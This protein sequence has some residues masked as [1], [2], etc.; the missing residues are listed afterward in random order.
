MAMEQEP[1]EIE[2]LDELDRR[3]DWHFFV[4]NFAADFIANAGLNVERAEL[5]LA[6]LEVRI[7]I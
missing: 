2:L 1:R 5:G 7:N 3:Q 4:N 6:Q